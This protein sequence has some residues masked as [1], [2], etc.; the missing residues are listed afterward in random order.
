MAV[1]LLVVMLAEMLT[2]VS[3]PRD[4]SEGNDFN[5]FY[6]N[7]FKVR[8]SHNERPPETRAGAEKEVSCR[9]R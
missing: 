5:L 2:L 8:L 1:L 7:P 4:A 3:T 6:K 9:R